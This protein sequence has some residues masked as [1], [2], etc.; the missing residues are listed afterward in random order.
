MQL[1]GPLLILRNLIIGSL[2]NLLT[3]ISRELLLQ[4]RLISMKV[5]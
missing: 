1:R 4:F 3:G 5:G 2:S